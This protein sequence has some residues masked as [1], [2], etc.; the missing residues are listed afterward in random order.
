MNLTL[1]AFKPLVEI[2]VFRR[3]KR[4]ACYIGPNA[5][6]AREKLSDASLSG[7]NQVVGGTERVPISALW[8]KWSLSF[9][10]QQIAS[11]IP[12]RRLGKRG[13]R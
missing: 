5:K 8:P 11:I 2:T 9:G 7:R 4:I 13:R 1:R 3:A 6:T 10:E 12:S